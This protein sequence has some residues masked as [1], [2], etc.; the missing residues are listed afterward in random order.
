MCSHR[1]LCFVSLPQRQFAVLGGNQWHSKASSIAHSKI[2]KLQIPKILET[3]TSRKSLCAILSA[4]RR[5]RHLS[6]LR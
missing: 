3:A 4:V 6:E 5:T 2:G 1:L